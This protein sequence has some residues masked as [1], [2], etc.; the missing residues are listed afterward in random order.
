MSAL[1]QKRTFVR[2]SITASAPASSARGTLRP[3]A[4]AVLMLITSSYLT[5]LDGKLARLFA[6]KDPEAQDEAS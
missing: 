3:S 5:G 2:Y 6:L 1:C 4:L